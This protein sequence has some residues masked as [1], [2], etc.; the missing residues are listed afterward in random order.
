MASVFDGLASAITGAF[1]EAVTL[2]DTTGAAAAVQAIFRESPIEFETAD[3]RPMA[4]VTP[5]L[6]V[7]KD[8]APL[9]AR[10]WTVVPASVAPRSF[11]V[12]RVWP[13]GSPG[14]DAFLICEMEEPQ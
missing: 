11:K 4:V 5:N 14:A 13:S 3:G 8:L 1:G 10:G 12:L 6:R 9:V 7:R 2:T